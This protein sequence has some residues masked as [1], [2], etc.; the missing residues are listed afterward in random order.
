MQQLHDYNEMSRKEELWNA[1]TH[2]LGL[3]ASMPITILLIQHAASLN[4][5]VHVVTYS[6][7]GASLIILFLMSTLL[8][9]M[10]M[11]YK[12]FFA[13]LD[14]SSIYILIAGAYT[15]F[16]LI[17]VG[18][19]LGITILSVVWS[20]AIFGV[21]FKFYFID[22]FEKL[23]LALYI[24]MGWLIIFAIKPIYMH[25]EWNGFIMLIIGG[26]LYTFGS[27]FF[28]WRSLPYS[29]VIWHVFV[30]AAT[31]CIVYCVGV[32]L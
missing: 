9:S 4:S 17:A 26:L 15:P 5:K 24:I 18:G 21:V 3:L 1:I 7:F 20:I 32:F 14:H 8:H 6:I 29:H 12:R 28:M 13:I 19:W 10:P 30:L 2:G 23:S 31:G 27:I 25:L 11:K 16:V 22:R